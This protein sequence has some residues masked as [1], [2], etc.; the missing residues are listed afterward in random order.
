MAH[1]AIYATVC[2]TPTSQSRS[3]KKLSRVSRL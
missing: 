3:E 1:P 2:D